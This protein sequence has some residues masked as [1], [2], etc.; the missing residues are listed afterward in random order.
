MYF[1]VNADDLE[2]DFVDGVSVEVRLID[3]N[4]STVEVVSGRIPYCSQHSNR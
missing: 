4:E 3:V 1:V 2:N